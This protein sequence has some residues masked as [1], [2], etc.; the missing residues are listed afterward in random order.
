M[1]PLF[2]MEAAQ[3]VFIIVYILYF[4]NKEVIV[5]SVW[6]VVYGVFIQITGRYNVP[7]RIKFLIDIYDIG[8]ASMCFKP[9]LQLLQHIALAYA[10]LTDKNNYHISAQQGNDMVEILGTFD[11]FHKQA[12]FCK[13]AKYTYEFQAYLLKVQGILWQ[14]RNICRNPRRSVRGIGP[15]TGQIITC[16]PTA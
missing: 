11:Y 8:C 10:A 16:P 12:V 4:V 6:Q 2:C 15:A 9:N 14:N 7:E 3:G 5:S 13:N 1:T